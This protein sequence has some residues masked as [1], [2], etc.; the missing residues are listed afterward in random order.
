MTRLSR[1]L[2]FLALVASAAVPA[3]AQDTKQPAPPTAPPAAPPA[4]GGTL[5]QFKYKAGQTQAYKATV[6]ID[7]AV[8]PEG[9]GAA[10]A[11][12]VPV[13]VRSVVAFSEKVMGTRKGTGTL[14]MPISSLV[15]TQEVAIIKAVVKYQNG[16]L[17]ASVNGKPQP[18]SANSAG[19]AELKKAAVLRRDPQG[20]VTPVG[21]GSDAIGQ[22]FGSSSYTLVQF[23]DKPVSVGDSWET[24]ER[25]RPSV[26]GKRVPFVIPEIEFKYTHTFKGIQEK[27]GRKT[28]LIETS[29]SGSTVGA[30]GGE[31]MLNQ[32]VTGTTRFDIARGVVVSSQHNVILSL[33]LGVPSGGAAAQPGGALRLDGSMDVVVTEA[34]GKPAAAGAKKKR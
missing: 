10:A 27:N 21:K 29:G 33:L 9:P 1:A 7:A 26:V 30:E 18:L 13:M 2:P 25:I 17:T 14:Q 32:S 34:A 28:A 31:N 15:T 12:P 4:E 22:L 24:V 11:N 8:S 6:K 3:L 5:L 19:L 20:K 23:P 16:K